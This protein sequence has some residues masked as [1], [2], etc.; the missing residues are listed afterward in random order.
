M[1]ADLSFD[2]FWSFR[3]P[4]SYLATPRLKKIV[5][6]HNVTVNVRPVYPIAVRIPGFFKTVNPQWPPYLLMDTARIAQM[7]QLPYAWPKPDPIV[8]DIASGEV[9]ED[10]PYIQRLTRLGVAAAEA[11]HGIDFLNEVSSIIFGGVPGWNEGDHLEKATARAGL[12][13]AELDTRIEADPDHFEKV[14]ED[15]EAAQKASGHW[16][17]PL[18]V[19]NGEPFFGQDRIDMLVWRMSQHGLVHNDKDSNLDSED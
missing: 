19:F 3:S 7:E 4:Y 12:D 11:G 8:M 18:M 5:E 15:N 9:P 14:I 1:A 17:V 2:L 13:L 16:G 6:T 10:Q